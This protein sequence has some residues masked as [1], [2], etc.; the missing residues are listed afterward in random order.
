MSDR[1]SITRLPIIVLGVVGSDVHCVANQL[2]ERELRNRKISFNNLGVAVQPSEFLEAIKEPNKTVILIGTLN[3]D[4]EPALETIRLLRHRFGTEIPIIVGGNLILGSHG[5]NRTLD[6][7]TTGASLILGNCSSIE[8]VVDRVVE[9][10][11]NS[12][13]VNI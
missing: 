13:L 5:R 8:E 4:I 7:R 12:V 3:G 6:L 11:S 9:F 2:L 1:E 10:I